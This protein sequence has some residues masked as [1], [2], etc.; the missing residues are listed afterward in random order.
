MLEIRG[1]KKGVSLKEYEFKIRGETH[2]KCLRRGGGM[3]VIMI[4][5][6]K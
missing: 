5:W 2:S 3:G 4:T 6:V 1:R